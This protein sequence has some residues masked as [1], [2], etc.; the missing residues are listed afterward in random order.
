[1]NYY[2]RLFFVPFKNIKTE[3]TSHNPEP[4]VLI[5]TKDTQW[6]TTIMGE[7]RC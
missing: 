6:I 1:M 5:I 7:E 2:A 4:P 3:T